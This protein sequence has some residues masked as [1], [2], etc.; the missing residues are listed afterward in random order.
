MTARRRLAG[1]RED[2]PLEQAGPYHAA[3]REAALEA[4]GRAYERA[5][6]RS[7]AHAF[8]GG[9]PAG[10]DAP[11]YV[12]ATSGDGELLVV[13]GA[14]P[15]A[16]RTCGRL[17]APRELLALLL[18]DPTTTAVWCDEDD[19]AGLALTAYAVTAG[20]DPLLLVAA[21]S[22][23]AVGE[24]AGVT[25]VEYEGARLAEGAWAADAL[26]AFLREHDGDAVVLPP[27]VLGDLAR[28]VVE[29][30]LG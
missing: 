19:G 7:H 1:I 21:R 26:D 30:D 17:V 28:H 12:V 3:A 9:T 25:Q 13:A 8:D 27:A 18:D 14:W 5:A 11:E 16:G 10:D 29:V 2:V 24:T 6:E 15:A 4:F 23:R 20:E 22:A